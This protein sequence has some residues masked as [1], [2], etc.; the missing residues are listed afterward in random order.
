MYKLIWYKLK[1][2]K[3]PRIKRI[4]ERLSD[5]QV[6]VQNN[7][8]LKTL[9]LLRKCEVLEQNLFQTQDSY[10]QKF[11]FLEEKVT[12]LQKAFENQVTTKQE[13]FEHKV[14]EL[15]ELYNSLSHLEHLPQHRVSKL[16]QEKANYILRSIDQEKQYRNYAVE[17]V[18][19]PLSKRSQKLQ[20]V[21]QNEVLERKHLLS[22]FSSNL[23]YQAAQTQQILHSEQQ[24][25]QE[26]QNAILNLIQEVML[27]LEQEILDEKASREYSQETLLNLLEETCTNLKSLMGC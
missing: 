3:V 8:S 21:L 25:R 5:L 20:T 18:L 24:N 4:S 9:S 13:L 1:M 2:S 19:E 12:K 27:Q 16:T 11:K 26:N 22:G 14:S 15:Q 7:E 10:S 23:N 17:S 6:S